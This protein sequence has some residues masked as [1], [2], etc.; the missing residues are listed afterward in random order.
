MDYENEDRLA[1][2]KAL[3]KLGICPNKECHR[4]YLYPVAYCGSECFG[5][6]HCGETWHIPGGIQSTNY[7]CFSPQ[8]VVNDPSTMEEA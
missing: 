6:L 1:L 8:G 4:A 2:R 3:P 5:C 7:W